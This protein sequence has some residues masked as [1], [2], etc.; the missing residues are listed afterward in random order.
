MARRPR[1]TPHNH[2]PPLLW[3]SGHVISSPDH[4]SEPAS[5]R[6]KIEDENSASRSGPQDL[7]PP[8]LSPQS[9]DSLSH[10][11]TGL[12]YKHSTPYNN[13]PGLRQHDR[14]PSKHGLPL[15]PRRP[16]ILSSMDNA[17]LPDPG[18]RSGAILGDVQKIAY[19]AEASPSK[20]QYRHGGMYTRTSQASRATLLT[21]SWESVC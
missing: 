5:K 16:Q 11:S 10:D 15:F 12:D 4:V 1:E 3:D 19:V 21:H 8:K 14:E 6:R 13:Q 18:R 17:E 20:P 7:S 2:S 9:L